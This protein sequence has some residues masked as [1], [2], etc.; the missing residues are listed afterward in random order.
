MKALRVFV[1]KKFIYQVRAKAET[2]I[3]T[4]VP[5][6]VEWSINQ[7]THIEIGQEKFQ[8]T[9]RN[10]VYI[11]K[12]LDWMVTFSQFFEVFTYAQVKPATKR[13]FPTN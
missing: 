6:G 8:K 7:I 11:G 9:F 1:D 3:A 10:C 12:N 13:I 5:L 4:F 2:S